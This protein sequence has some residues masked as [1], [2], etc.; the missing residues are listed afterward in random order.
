M[1]VIDYRGFRL[2]ATSLLP[3]TKTSI[4]HGSFDA[5]KTLHCDPD[6]AP[7]VTRTLKQLN[8]KVTWWLCLWNGCSG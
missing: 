3:I 5:G 6:A 2:L 1:V 8:L 4:L 7:I